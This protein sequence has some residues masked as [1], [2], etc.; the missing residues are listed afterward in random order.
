MDE[1]DTDPELDAMSSV[2]A[3]LSAL[4][5]KEMQARVL[6]WVAARLGVGAT[7]LP[8]IA[9]QGRES[10]GSAR[11]G[12]ITTVAARLNVKSC[13]DLLV[14]AATHLSLYQGKEKFSRA[15]WVACAKDAKQWKVDYSVQTATA[16]GRMLNAGFVNETAKDVFSVQDEELRN[17]EAKL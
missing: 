15:D 17:I 6:A 7:T 14:A 16:I 8:A 12:T 13:R 5:D 1:T 10:K 11:E 9:V 4:E 3:K 2:L